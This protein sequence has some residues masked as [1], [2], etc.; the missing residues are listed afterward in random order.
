MQLCNAKTKAGTPCK[1]QLGWGTDHPGSGRCRLHGGAGGSSI[2][3]GRYSV[4][5][6]QSLAVKLEQFEGDPTPY[7]LDSELAMMRAL[8]QEYLARF[9]DGVKLPHDDINRLMAML[10]TVSKL[11]ERIMKI[12]NDTALTQ[13]ELAYIKTRMADELPH[14]IP[15]V[16]D[17]IAFVR[18]I[19]GTVGDARRSRANA[20]AGRTIDG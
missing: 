6:R 12:M 15:D 13:A 10:E 19:F 4:K 7:D 11:V 16:A 3:H 14:Y 8:F 18:A 5:H 20:L 1:H 2:K 17:Q 9:D